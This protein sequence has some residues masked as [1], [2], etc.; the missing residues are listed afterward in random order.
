MKSVLAA[1][2]HRMIIVQTIFTNS[3]AHRQFALAQFRRLHVLYPMVGESGVNRFHSDT[4]M[5]FVTLPWHGLI[6]IYLRTTL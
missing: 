3:R 6:M 5:I 4:T 2:G 1:T